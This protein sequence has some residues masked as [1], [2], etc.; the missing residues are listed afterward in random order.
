MSE[1]VRYSN[2][3][4]TCYCQIKLDSGERILI[5]IATAPKPCVK[6]IKLVCHGMLPI[7]TIWE[8]NPTM[9]GG[10][11]AYVRNMM[12]MF[13]SIEPKHPLDI[14]RDQLLP[15]KSIPEVQKYLLDAESGMSKNKTIEEAYAEGKR[16]ELE[17]RLKIKIPTFQ[18]WLT[19]DENSKLERKDAI[20]AYLD[21]L[22]KFLV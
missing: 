20:D 1:I 14:L 3:K 12:Q 9:A 16:R 18:E 11:D 21:C 2:T 15:C 17:K 13:I 7:Q 8:Y 6:V 10:Y 4:L 19:S 5:S 22:E